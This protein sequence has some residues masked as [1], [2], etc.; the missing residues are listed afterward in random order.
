MNA[1][2]RVGN[3]KN[4]LLGFGRPKSLGWKPSFNGNQAVTETAKRLM[5]DL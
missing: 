4:T 5:G 2:N 1:K 3:V